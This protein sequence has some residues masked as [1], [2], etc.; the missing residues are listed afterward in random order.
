MNHIALVIVSRWNMMTNIALYMMS[1]EIIKCLISLELLSSF[2]GKEHF[3]K[4]KTSMCHDTLDQ[5][6]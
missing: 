1:K 3:K 2:L 6:H 5:D 4:K